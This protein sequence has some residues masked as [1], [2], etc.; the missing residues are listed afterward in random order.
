M[1]PRVYCPGRGDSITREGLGGIVRGGQYT[2]G[3]IVQ[4]TM[5]PRLCC[6]GGQYLRG[7]YILP[8]L[9]INTV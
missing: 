6:P 9:I 7:Q 4:G 2:L 5:Q 8:P 3:Y 1:Y